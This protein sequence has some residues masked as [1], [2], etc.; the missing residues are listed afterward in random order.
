MNP[1]TTLRARSKFVPPLLMAG[2]LFAAS[3]EAQ[4]V[5]LEDNFNSYTT[6][7]LANSSSWP[8]T[9]PGTSPALSWTTN[10][11]GP[12]AIVDGAVAGRS[13]K[14]YSY[15]EN[16]TGQT[17]TY[18]TVQLN[19]AYS[20]TQDWVLSLDFYIESMPSGISSGTFAIAAISNGGITT[21]GSLVTSV[22]VIRT[23]S[24]ANLNVFISGGAGVFFGTPFLELEEWYTLTITGN[25]GTQNVSVNISGASYNETR[26]HTY[27]NTHSEFNTL[28]IGD[29]VVNAFA[30]DR[31]NQAYL[32]NFSLVA[33]PEP[34]TAGLLLVGLAGW[35]LRRRC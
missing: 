28:T 23:Q 29:W 13:G 2:L 9:I 5:L 33:I 3:L 1:E 12:Q 21:A 10:T 25:N 19:S 17:S 11:G 6:G 4:I 24:N 20:G 32:D 27:A 26:S 16:A 22:S 35:L 18:S 31:D 30:T 7:A 15:A 8:S 34:A 14:L